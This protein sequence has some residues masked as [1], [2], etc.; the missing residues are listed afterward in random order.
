V[1]DKKTI[2]VEIKTK[3]MSVVKSLSSRV[4]IIL[5][6]IWLFVFIG[7]LETFGVKRISFCGN[8]PPYSYFGKQTIVYASKNIVRGWIKAA[9]KGGFNID[10]G[11]KLGHRKG[12]SES[13]DVP[14]ILLVFIGVWGSAII[15]VLGAILYFI[16]IE[17]II[18][19][20][21]LRRNE[22]R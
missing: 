12:V 9:Y 16:V 3:R 11:A 17:P 4:E 15:L 2:H 13:E 10:M 22:R 1:V 19:K 8:P 18:E 14:I 20:R 7:Y 5:L 21:G 6:S